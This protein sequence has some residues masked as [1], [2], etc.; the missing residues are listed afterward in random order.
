MG[1]MTFSSG[2]SS[3]GENPPSGPPTGQPF[4]VPQGRYDHSNT[5]PTNQSSVL[6]NGYPRSVN[7]ADEVSYHEA[8]PP[9]YNQGGM[10][11]HRN[12]DDDDDDDDEIHPT[13]DQV[14]A[15]LSPHV[16]L[17]HRTHTIDAAAPSP[18]RAQLAALLTQPQAIQRGP[19]RS[20]MHVRSGSNRHVG[21]P[22]HHSYKQSYSRIDSVIDIAPLAE[23]G[24]G[25]NSA[26]Q[27]P[28][29][30]RIRFHEEG[31][32]AY[33]MYDDGMDPTRGDWDHID[34]QDRRSANHPSNLDVSLGNGTQ[35]SPTGLGSRPAP[36]SGGQGLT[37]ILPNYPSP[38]PYLSPVNRSASPAQPRQHTSDGHA[39]GLSPPTS[40]HHLLTPTVDRSANNSATNS[41]MNTPVVNGSMIIPTYTDIAL[42]PMSTRSMSTSSVKYN[43][44]GAEIALAQLASPPSATALT[45]PSSGSQKAQASPPPASSGSHFERPIPPKLTVLPSGGSPPAHAGVSAALPPS[46]AGSSAR[47]T[48]A[49]D[50]AS[51]ITEEQKAAHKNAQLAPGTGWAPANAINLSP[52]V[53]ESGQASPSTPYVP[54]SSLGSNSAKGSGS[55]KPSPGAAAAKRGSKAAMYKDSCRVLVVEG[56][57]QQPDVVKD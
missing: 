48:H 15:I 47:S 6:Q 25:A 22:P 29:I 39:R 4:P 28:S 50:L 16:G 36:P 17:V 54:G 57:C 30:S 37:P 38:A 32:D 10:L 55:A 20:A 14:S 13:R 8:P 44:T 12:P 2:E 33:G 34:H 46:S 9:M 18:R 5:T 52:A 51:F 49:I 45:A 40:S 19:I 31:S 27:E 3:P 1:S 21:L 43:D 53:A 23:S 35:R 56:Q 41:A 11:M 7:F 26:D 24:I 42:N